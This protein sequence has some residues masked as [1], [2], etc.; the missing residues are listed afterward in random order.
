MPATKPRRVIV[1]EIVSL[2]G[3]VSGPDGELDFFETVDDYSE[4]DSDNLET[5]NRVDTVLLGAATYRMFVGYWPTA[6]GEPVADR[7][8]STAKVVFSSTLSSAP[9]GSFAPAE[10][11]SSDAVE[12]VRQLREGEGGDLIVWGSIALARALLAAE[13]VDD[14]YLD[15]LPILV[16]SGRTLVEAGLPDRILRLADTRPRRSGIVS[17]RYELPTA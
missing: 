12:H 17:L 9:W 7:L 2:D 4:V 3:F 16:G 1:Q 11:V 14:L 15:V 6:T 13:L 8:N 5:L 10:I